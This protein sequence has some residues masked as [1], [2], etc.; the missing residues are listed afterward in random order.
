[1]SNT[2]N[3]SEPTSPLGESETRGFENSLPYYDN[4]TLRD[5]FAGQALVGLLA[6]VRYAFDKG[7]M[8]HGVARDVFSFADA[9]IEARKGG[10]V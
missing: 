7:E 5:Y 8:Q 4:M 1:M 2:N 6:N 9:M 10:S 3:N